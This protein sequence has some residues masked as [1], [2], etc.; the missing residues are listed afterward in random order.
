MEEKGLGLPGR[1][2][3]A[4]IPANAPAVLPTLIYTTDEM[5]NNMLV[6]LEKLLYSPP[7]P[8]NGLK[9]LQGS[10]ESF[11]NHWVRAAVP[12]GLGVGNKTNNQPWPCDQRRV[13]ATL[14]A[15]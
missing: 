9:D 4:L 10:G 1:Q 8:K 13:G 7:L 11:E 15:R 6:L 3:E 5:K 14:V 2:C 12:A